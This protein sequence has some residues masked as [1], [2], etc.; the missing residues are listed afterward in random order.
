[1]EEKLPSDI[2]DGGIGGISKRKRLSVEDDDDLLLREDL[3]GDDPLLA[4]ATSADVDGDR[5]E[6]LLNIDIN[7]DQKR[8]KEEHKD[9]QQE[10]VQQLKQPQPRVRQHKPKQKRRRRQQKTPPPP[11]QRRARSQEE[12]NG[13]NEGGHADGANV[14][15]F[16]QYLPQALQ[17]LPKDRR[18]KRT[19][20]RIDVKEALFKAVDLH[21]SIQNVETL[22]ANGHVLEENTSA[23]SRI[24]DVLKDLTREYNAIMSLESYKLT[25]WELQ[26]RALVKYYN[27]HGH[28]NVGKK[29]DGELC[30]WCVT[31]RQKYHKHNAIET[32]TSKVENNENGNDNLQQD[33][34]SS[35]V[36]Q[37]DRETALETEVT[38]PVE[39][40]NKNVDSESSAVAE[41]S[42]LTTENAQ[43]ASNSSNSEKKSL[44]RTT[45]A[46][47]CDGKKFYERDKF[48]FELLKR[49]DFQFITRRRNMS[50]ESYYQTLVEWKKQYGSDDKNNWPIYKDKTNPAL[51]VWVNTIR[52][53]YTKFQQG[54]KSCLTPER[55]QLLNGISFTW[56]LKSQKTF[57]EVRTGFEISSKF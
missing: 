10:E 42:A 44:A 45:T 17:N 4:V 52:Y 12:N 37:A 35:S 16:L 32:P 38:F 22:F 53:E 26:F 56:K 18:P 21:R 55:I 50:F 29:E 48:N 9:E 43:N 28:S 47:N 5:N 8:Q 3:H 20:H 49:L 57:E 1:M 30:A 25:N 33:S 34:A 46:A 36:G 40:K 39:T 24:S 11:Q 27:E 2:N 54:R 7:N 13:D 14:D 23:F 31:Q 51:G 41:E 15:I 6:F 19:I